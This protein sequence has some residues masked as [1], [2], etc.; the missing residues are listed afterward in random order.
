M[1]ALHRQILN[2]LSP[3]TMAE[4][5]LI[6]DLKT[7]AAPVAPTITELELSHYHSYLQN[8]VEVKDRV[9]HFKTYKECFLG[10]YV[11]EKRFFKN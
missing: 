2:R 7:P 9:Y 10:R 5:Q 4:D 8:N 11:Q 1:Q 6:C 3:T